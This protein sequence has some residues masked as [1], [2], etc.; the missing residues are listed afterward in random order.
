MK[1]GGHYELRAF[2]PN[3]TNTKC[4]LNL[5]FVRALRSSA[6]LLTLSPWWQQQAYIESLALSWPQ[7]NLLCSLWALGTCDFGDSFWRVL[8]TQFTTDALDCTY[9]NWLQPTKEL[10]SI[11]YAVKRLRWVKGYV[12]WIGKACKLEAV[13]E[14]TLVPSARAQKR[15]LAPGWVINENTTTVLKQESKLEE[16]KHISRYFKVLTLLICLLFL[17]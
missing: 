4:K 6:H 7:G 12:L 8:L 5:N 15:L 9:G 16:L 13:D 10:A 2:W 3:N 17:R 1:E 11:S 14:V